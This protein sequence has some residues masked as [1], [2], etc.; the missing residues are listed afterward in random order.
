[1]PFNR[2]SSKNAKRFL[3]GIREISLEHMVEGWWGDLP[4]KDFNQSE[5]DL[6]IHAVV[7]E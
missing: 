5:R 3:E 1:M 2:K 7:K 4:E 6:G